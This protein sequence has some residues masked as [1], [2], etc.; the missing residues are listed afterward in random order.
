MIDFF[1]HLFTPD[2]FMPRWIC[3]RWSEGHGWLY[4]V[5]NISIFIAYFTIPLL[6]LS[7]L[8]RRKNT[9]FRGI[10][11]WFSLFIVFCGL[12]HLVD[13][14]MFWYPVYRL[15][16]ILLSTTAL[17]SLIT[18]FKLYK[19]IPKALQLKSLSE[20]ENELQRRTV[21]LEE[22][23]ILLHKR[24]LGF[25][26]L[27]NSNPDMIAEFDAKLTYK[28]V[29]KAILNAV[30]SGRKSEDFIGKTP[31]EVLPTHPHTTAFV[32]NLQHVKTHLEPVAYEVN[33]EITPGSNFYFFVEMIPLFDENNRFDGVL[34]ITKN[35][36]ND[37]LR[38]IELNANI[39]DL[40]KLSKRLDYKI[41][42]LQEFAYIV[43]HNLRSPVGNLV[44]LQ[45]LFDTAETQA[46]KLFFAT[47]TFEVIDGLNNTVKDLSDVVSIDQNTHIERQLLSFE[48]VLQSQITTISQQIQQ[49]G[50][51]ITTNFSGCASICYPKIYLDSILLNLL[52]NAVKYASPHRP[53]TIHFTT[54][55]TQKGIIV[56]ECT[57]NGLGIDLEK[58]GHKIFSLHKT[59]HNNADARGVG[60]FITKNQIQSLGGRISVKSTPNVGSTFIIHFNEMDVL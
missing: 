16:A 49:A 28:F 5:A 41:H 26:T 42:T 57:D 13:A 24:E 18:V 34:A 15:N 37:R 25:K 2:G 31:V 52:T 48:E 55:V 59:F 17:V 19:L 53:P 1:K 20:L 43:S 27:V 4:I 11:I 35:V 7:F 8:K 50:A 36:T 54:Y 23:N 21:E 3:G 32:K 6:L 60:L 46:E 30:G 58:Y 45:K 14:I 33:T 12:T 38:E 40:N 39:S 51:T 44:S 22:T 47:K 10:F 56:L 29:N 9:S